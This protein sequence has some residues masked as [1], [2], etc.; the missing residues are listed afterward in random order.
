GRKQNQLVFQPTDNDLPF[1]AVLLAV[2]NEEKV[3]EQKIKSVFESDYPQD[4]I[5]FYI[6][7]DN[8]TDR[9]NNIIQHYQQQYP[10]LH[11]RLFNSRTGKAGIINAL[12]DEATAPVLILT[13][14]NVFFDRSTIY[15]LARHYKN[16]EIA[17]VGGNILNLEYKN[18]GISYQERA[19]LLRENLIKYQEG[20]L[21]GAMIGAIGGCY[22][23]RK[24]YFKPV[25]QNYLVDDFYIT[26]H[27]LACGK[28][29]INELEAICFEDVSDKI[30][31]EFR[32][33]VRISAGNFQNLAAFKHLLWPPFTGLA[34]AFWS[35][36]VLRWYT[37]FLLVLIFITNLFLVQEGWLY[38]LSLLGQ[39]LLFAT[40]LLDP[41]LKKMNIHIRLF[42]FITHFYSMNM[43]L[44]MGWFR[45]MKGIKTSVWT[46]TQRFQ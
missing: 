15:Q 41:L 11:F 6:G 42:R 8:S 2:Y 4:K 25:P 7:S 46:P 31:E 5:T 9:T 32:R 19:Y 34:F 27:V 17:L 12:A 21:W 40:L 44:L 14:A 37:P 1:V 10:Q 26:M 13:D 18:S 38:Q 16:Q 22:S 33:K 28:K 30:S 45:Y 35:H 29:A 36:K 39:V 43:A 24:M 23:I 20:V 3:I